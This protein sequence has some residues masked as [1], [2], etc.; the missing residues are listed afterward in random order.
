[1]RFLAVCADP[2]CT[3]LVRGG[4]CSAHAAEY[5]RGIKDRSEWRWVYGDRRWRAL[6]RQVRQ[7]QPWCIVTG[8]HELT[9]DVDHIVALQDGGS[10]FARENVQGMCHAHHS[11]KTADEVNGRRERGTR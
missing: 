7:E 6:R 9:A 11:A 2:N 8:C 3:E 10:P 1:M 5:D 4:R